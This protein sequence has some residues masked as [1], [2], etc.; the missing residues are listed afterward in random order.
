M[1]PR[2]WLIQDFHLGGASNGQVKKA[3]NKIKFLRHYL[4]ILPNL[5]GATAPALLHLGLPLVLS[6]HTFYYPMVFIFE[7]LLFYLF[8]FSFMTWNS[9]VSETIFGDNRTHLY[10]FWAV[11]KLSIAIFP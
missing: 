2:Q 10:V 1:G 7:N 4:R 11:S 9:Q 8:Y 6:P 3:N 5:V